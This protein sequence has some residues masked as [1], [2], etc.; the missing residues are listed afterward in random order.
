MEEHLIYWNIISWTQLLRLWMLNSF[1]WHGMKHLGYMWLMHLCALRHK[2][3]NCMWLLH[4][5]TNSCTLD[6]LKHKTVFQAR[7]TYKWFLILC[8]RN[9]KQVWNSKISQN[10]ECVIGWCLWLSCEKAWCLWLRLRILVVHCWLGCILSYDLEHLSL[11][12]LN[13]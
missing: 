1:M 5:P 13:L 10:F 9:K 2:C 4:L 6:S 3:L 11:W 7:L 12:V 8:V